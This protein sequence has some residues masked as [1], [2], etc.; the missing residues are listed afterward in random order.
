MPT[1][2]TLRLD[3]ALITA[4]KA[5]AHAHG[6]SVSV[7]VADYFA[8][9]TQQKVPSN[10]TQPGTPATGTVTASLLGALQAGPAAHNAAAPDEA[11]YKRHLEAKFR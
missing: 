5:Y 9:L 8:Q 1:K 10:T 3:E 2:L 6:R 11:D 4:A 7:L